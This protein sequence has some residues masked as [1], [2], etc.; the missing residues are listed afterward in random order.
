V[1]KVL[2]QTVPE[3]AKSEAVREMELYFATLLRQVDSS[4]LEEWERMREPELTARASAAPRA[5]LELV[6][7]AP[8]ASEA[9]PDITRDPK[10]FTAAIRHG[11]FTFLRAWASG[12]DEE[13]LSLLEVS[14]GGPTATASDSATKIASPQAVPECPW[15]VARLAAARRGYLTDHPSLLLTPEARNLRHTY[16]QPSEDGNHWRLQQMLVDPEGHNDWVAEFVVDLVRSR[17]A[18]EPVL[19][20]MRLGPLVS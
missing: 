6:L 2:R 5:A 11:V 9:P 17:R 15:N 18:N 12:D 20:L 3:T 1:F 4:L 16:L 19:V 10:A 7:P 8:G 13:A 14:A